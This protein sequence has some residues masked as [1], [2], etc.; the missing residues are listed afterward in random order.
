ME[1]KKEQKLT[2]QQY[3]DKEPSD[4]EVMLIKVQRNN[5]KDKPDSYKTLGIETVYRKIKELRTQYKVRFNYKNFSHLFYCENARREAIDIIS[6]SLE[7]EVVINGILTNLIGAATYKLGQFDDN[8]HYAA[9]LKSLCITNALGQEFNCF[10]RNL[11]PR[12]YLLQEQGEYKIP[13][14]NLIQQAIYKVASEEEKEVLELEHDY[15][16]G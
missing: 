4:E 16:I 10:G 6:G 12:N 7:V 5:G 8:R 9:T 13:K 1:A 15:S 3:L 2:L 11:N 14:A